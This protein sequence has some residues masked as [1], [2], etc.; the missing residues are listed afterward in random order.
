MSKNQYALELDQLSRKLF[1]IHKSLIDFQKMVYESLE[2]K[3]PNP[4]EM[5]HL[6][7]NHED[8][9]WLRVLSTLMA[10]IDE[11]AEDKKTPAT[12]E[13]VKT[14]VR[15]LKEIFISPEFHTDFKNRMM[16]A[17]TKDKDLV[18]QFDDLKKLLST[19]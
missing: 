18:N 19:H 2:N 8:F 9:A 14:V 6:L 3:K 10:H 11:T 4:Y 5:L 12:A 15:E 16:I 13:S 17:L 7:M 1:K